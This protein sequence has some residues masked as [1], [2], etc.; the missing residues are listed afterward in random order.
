MYVCCILDVASVGDIK[1]LIKT[2]KIRNVLI[3]LPD[4]IN[5]CFIKSGR[6]YNA[7]AIYM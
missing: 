4:T 6:L 2:V 5:E 7:V 1:W 3:F